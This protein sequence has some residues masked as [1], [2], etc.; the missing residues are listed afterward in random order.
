MPIAVVSIPVADQS[1]ALAFYTD[2]MGFTLLR[3]EAMGPAMRWIQL[4]PKTGGATVA[5]A[6]WLKRMAP[7]SLQGLLLH[8]ADID[9]EHARLAGLGVTLSPIEEQPWGRFTMMADPDGN[10]WVVAQLTAPEEIAAR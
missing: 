6:T 10:G 2:V 1:A 8:V 9:A 4:Q 3:D 5:L 7:G